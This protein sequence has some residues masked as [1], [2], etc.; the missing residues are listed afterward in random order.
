MQPGSPPHRPRIA[1]YV[2]KD[3]IAGRGATLRAV[4]IVFTEARV[5]LIV[6][7]QQRAQ[8]VDDGRFAYVVATDQDIQAGLK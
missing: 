6:H 2:L 3:D 4:Y 5:R 1:R 8:G 7:G